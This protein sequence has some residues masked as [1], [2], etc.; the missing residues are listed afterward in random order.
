MNMTSPKFDNDATKI[1][2]VV[3]E[4]TAVGEAAG[5]DKVDGEDFVVEDVVVVSCCR[6][7]SSVV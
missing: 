4:V 3:G 1:A 7:L 6:A 2:C 5:A